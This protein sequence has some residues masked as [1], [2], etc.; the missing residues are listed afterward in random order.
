MSFMIAA[1]SCTP[2]ETGPTES[3]RADPSEKPPFD[4]AVLAAT[5][6]VIQ[7]KDLDSEVQSFCTGAAVGPR[8][9][10]TAAHCVDGESPKTRTWVVP[11]EG[12]SVEV[13]PGQETSV[14]A[15]VEEGAQF[16]EIAF[17]RTHPTADVATLALTSELGSWVG[18]GDSSS[19]QKGR[20]LTRTGYGKKGE[21]LGLLRSAG[22]EIVHAE[23][24][25]LWVV[26]SQG[27][28][29]CQGDSGGGLFGIEAGQPRLLGVLTDGHKWCKGADRY[30]SL[31]SLDGWV[32]RD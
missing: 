24:S 19:L 1:W 11:G 29:A 22:T 28:G 4:L 26:A 23:G 30:V 17:Q 32:H 8:K 16:I 25:A 6:R 21:T 7:A 18:L 2:M 3:R 9:V 10:V 20:R 5:V 31:S 14:N 27:E 13:R 12:K 15:L